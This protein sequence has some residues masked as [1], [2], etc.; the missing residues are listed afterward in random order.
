MN[1]PPQHFDVYRLSQSLAVD[2]LE[3]CNDFPRG[4]GSLRDQLRRSAQAVA[5]N[6]AEGLGRWKAGEKRA[7]YAVARGELFE[8]RAALDLAHGCA[9][10]DTDT[11]AS[12]D[13]RADR[14]GAMLWKLIRRFCE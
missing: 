4:T 13:A 1:T 8:T 3:L 6:V 12:L 5:L 11:H 7:A 2:V 14:I 9:L 10:V